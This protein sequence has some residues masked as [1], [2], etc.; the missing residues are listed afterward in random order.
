MRVPTVLRDKVGFSTL[1]AAGS[2]PLH[3]LTRM[4]TVTRDSIIA[5]PAIQ[6]ISSTPLRMRDVARHATGRVQYDR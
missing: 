5:L 3:L 4:T 1:Q 2:F 6:L